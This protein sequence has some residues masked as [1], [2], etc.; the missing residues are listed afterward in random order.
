[1]RVERGS[2]VG[3]GHGTVD[4]RTGKSHGGG[5]GMESGGEGGFPRLEA[6]GGHEGMVAHDPMINPLARLHQ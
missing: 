2:G 3:K 1:V 4:G 6:G 5:R